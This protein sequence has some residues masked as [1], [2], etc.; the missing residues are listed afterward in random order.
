MRYLAL[1]ITA[2]FLIGCVFAD[3][4]TINANV[5]V[6]Y[7]PSNIIVTSFTAANQVIQGSPITFYAELE[8]TGPQAS[9]NITI[10]IAVSGSSS[11]SLADEVGAL[12]PS[13]NEIIGVTMGNATEVQGG[14]TASLSANYTSS[15]SETADTNTR[16]LAYSVTSRSG[17]VAALNSTP[18]T[19]D[20]PSNTAVTLNFSNSDALLSLT[21]GSSN[22]I[23]VNAVISNATSNSILLAIPTP[24]A[25]PDTVAILNIS[26]T[27]T[28]N[29]VVNAAVSIPYDC[30]DT[31]PAPYQLSGGSWTEITPYSNNLATCTISFSVSADPVVA[32]LAKGIVHQSPQGGGAASV[33]GV[34]GGGGLEGGGT[35]RP[36]VSILNNTCYEISNLTPPG[37]A[38]VGFTGRSFNIRNNFISPTDAGI[39][40]G[41]ASSYSIYQGVPLSI[42]RTASYNYTIELRNISYIPAV[43]TIVADLCSEPLNSSLAGVSTTYEQQEQESQQLNFI[44]V[45]PQ[46]LLDFVPMLSSLVQGESSISNIGLRNNGTAAELVSIS[47]PTG[48]SGLVSF[49]SN[50]IL[51]GPKQSAN[52]AVLFEAPQAYYPGTYII[53]INITTTSSGRSSTQTQYISSTIYPNETEQPYILNQV[54]LVNN[55]GEVSGIMEIR[56]PPGTNLYNLSVKTIIPLAVAPNVSDISAFGIDS[57]IGVVNNNYEIDWH[58]SSLPAGMSIYGYY[59]IRNL[60]DQAYLKFSQNL[61]LEPSAL[62]PS[63]VIKVLQITVPAMYA[64]QNGSIQ[65]EVFYT[66]SQY[67]QV[68]FTLSGPAD[69]PIY[70]ASQ[71]VNATPNSDMVVNFGIRPDAAGTMLLNLYLSA[72]GQNL[73]YPVTVLVLPNQTQGQ[74]AA[75]HSPLFASRVAAILFLSL[76]TVVALIAIY[77]FR[78]RKPAEAGAAFPRVHRAAAEKK[79]VVEKESDTSRLKEIGRQLDESE[80]RGKGGREKKTEKGMRKQPRPQPERLDRLKRIRERIGRA[81]RGGEGR[82]NQT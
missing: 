26:I 67:G 57:Q 76:A 52:V 61:L 19:V 12:S 72:E 8:N 42:G 78:T 43:H 6:V 5:N 37:Y 41:N 10:R 48:Y 69:S 56:A 28:T 21:T 9:G 3:S 23:P 45:M 81:H 58:V 79:S 4:N 77:L 40:V 27:D 2:F 80:S 15:N 51:L 38:A 18:V 22:T 70:R 44:T 50:E 13:Q 63:Q 17:Q 60:Q 36:T 71:A 20:L 75:G 1:L 49:S 31:S 7:Q 46:L 24:A 59:T 68:G 47:T 33:E 53:P 66:G 64:R 29:T 25:A 54:S 55:T 35:F 14:Y 16:S 82:E 73:T 65:A 30:G 62:S 74:S 32:I 11:A 39:T 34:G